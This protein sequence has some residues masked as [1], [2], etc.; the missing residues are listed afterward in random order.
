MMIEVCGSWC[1]RYVA[2]MIKHVGPKMDW[3]KCGVGMQGVRLLERKR[4]L[5]KLEKERL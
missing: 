4:M 5:S 2:I 1:L 3:W